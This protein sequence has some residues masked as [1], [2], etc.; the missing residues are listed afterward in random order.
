ML[1]NVPM[2]YET[3]LTV[4]ELK[5]LEGPLNEFKSFPP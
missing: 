1:Q 5:N 3:E 4:F 2:V